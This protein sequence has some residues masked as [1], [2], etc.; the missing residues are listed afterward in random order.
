MFMKAKMY[1]IF[2]KPDS[3][4]PGFEKEKINIFISIIHVILSAYILSMCYETRTTEIKKKSLDKLSY[5]Y[6]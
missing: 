4:F 6:N 1:S 3:A 2:F 5:A